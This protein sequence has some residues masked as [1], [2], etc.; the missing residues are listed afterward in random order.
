MSP[1][2][3]GHAVNQQRLLRMLEFLP[4]PPSKRKL[5]ADCRTRTSSDVC[6]LLDK[7]MD[8]QAKVKTEPS[9]GYWLQYALDR[10][11]AHRRTILKEAFR[12]GWMGQLGHW[13][14]ATYLL[15]GLEEIRD[16]CEATRR[17]W[18]L[19]IEAEALQALGQA[20]LRAHHVASPIEPAKDRI[21]A[22]LNDLI[23]SAGRKATETQ[24]PEQLE[25]IFT[26][27]KVLSKLAR[28]V[29]QASSQL[30]YLCQAFEGRSQA[31]STPSRR[32]SRRVSASQPLREREEGHEAE[33]ETVG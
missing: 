25:A 7:M 28:E 19:T 26:S 21:M 11:A 23:R 15:V 30:Q 17:K 8:L 4:F 33:G 29:G 32:A 1:F 14:Q 13:A 10:L 24:N 5:C 31:K 16:I 2:P 12:Q 18:G 6:A 3:C 9:R 27:A 20:A 22:G